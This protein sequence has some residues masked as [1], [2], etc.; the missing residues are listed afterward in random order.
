[1][2]WSL[3]TDDFR[4]VCDNEKYPLLA[5]IATQLNGDSVKD[6]T[7]PPEERVTGPPPEVKPT[8]YPG[9]LFKCTKDGYFRDPSDCSTF[10]YCVPQG[11]GEFARHTYSCGENAAFDENTK[12]CTF[13]NQVPGC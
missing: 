8:A 3:E 11:N 9:E 2:I 1:M 5:K 12:T 4:G 10:Y 13:K 7:V 6:Q